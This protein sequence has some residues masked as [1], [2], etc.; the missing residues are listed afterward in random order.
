MGVAQFEPRSNPQV[1]RFIWE[2]MLQ[3]QKKFNILRSIR[4]ILL[5]AAV[6][7]SIYYI[8][9]GSDPM[10]IFLGDDLLVPAVTEPVDVGGESIY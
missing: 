6:L 1:L 7:I 10:G 3:V 9:T 2:A 5:I 4:L 8:L